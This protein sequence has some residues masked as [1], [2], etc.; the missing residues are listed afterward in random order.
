MVAEERKTLELGCL[1]DGF[2]IRDEKIQVR[3]RC[4][5]IGK[6]AAARVV[7]MKTVARAERIEP[8]APN[9]RFPIVLDVGQPMRRAD[10]REAVTVHGKRNACP[11]GR[12]R[13]A[14]VLLESAH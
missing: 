13:E 7:P 3:N 2:E 6:A 1:D 14:D 10:E 12:M 8:W 9:G 11:I 5:A 4:V